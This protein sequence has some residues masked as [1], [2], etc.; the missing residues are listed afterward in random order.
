MTN[1]GLKFTALVLGIALVIVIIVLI[2]GGHKD[3]YAQCGTNCAKCDSVGTCITCVAGYYP[4]SKRFNCL[5]GCEA[6]YEQPAGCGNQQGQ[7]DGGGDFGHTYFFGLDGKFT[8]GGPGT[9][10]CPSDYCQPGLC[11]VHDMGPGN[12]SRCYC[13][14]DPNI[15]PSACTPEN[16]SSLQPGGP[17]KAP[18][19]ALT[20]AAANT[21]MAND[22]WR[23]YFFGPATAPDVFFTPD[24]VHK[25]SV[26]TC[27]QCGVNVCN[28][29]NFL[30]N[31]DWHGPAPPI[32]SG[33][34]GD[35]RPL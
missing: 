7:Y 30:Y 32:G 13:T 17:P 4:D 24:N 8:W 34:G 6:N 3:K 16:Q 22:P 21:S 28:T 23:G 1:E 2:A 12:G 14:S 5:A 29:G 15:P 9:F 10:S 26:P 11:A 35:V 27:N 25:F 18:N 19:A 31:G 20:A 33:P